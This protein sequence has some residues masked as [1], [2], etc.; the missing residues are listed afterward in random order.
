MEKLT[1]IYI[2]SDSW[3][4][5]VYECNERFFV[6]TDPR[7][8]RRPHICTKCNNEFDGEPDTPISED[9]EVEFFPSRMTWS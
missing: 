2:G 9:I 6:D 1:L 4:R 5:P 8:H 7:S 3:S